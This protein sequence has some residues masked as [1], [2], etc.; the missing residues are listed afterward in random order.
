MFKDGAAGESDGARPLDGQRYVARLAQR[1]VHWLT[2]QSHAGRLY[3]VDIRLRP[4]GGKGL[5]VVSLDAFGE[6][7]R[8]RAWIWEQQAL[9]RARGIAGD[10]A[11]LASFAARRAA[12]LAQPREV[13][14]VR[15]QV[16]SMRARWRAERDR[17]TATVLDLKQGAGALLDIEFLLQALVLMHAHAH[18]GLSRDG[19]TV[20]LINAAAAAGILDERQAHALATAHADLLGRA[21]ACTLDA[22]PRLVA[23]D[24]VLAQHCAA[25]LAAAAAVGLAFG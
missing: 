22:R 16:T 12:V 15:E 7:Q 19:N 14:A 5:L 17:S 24:A 3:D 9:V 23:R 13:G 20:A 18:P 8:E 6:Y 2:V 10:A 1:V 25:V 4:D 21:L 11:T